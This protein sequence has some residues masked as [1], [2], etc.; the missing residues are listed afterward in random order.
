MG[1][2]GRE[3]RRSR[4]VEVSTD[5]WKTWAEA[6]LTGESVHPAWRLWEWNWQ[7]P[8]VAGPGA[9]M[10]RATDKRNRVQPMT[11]DVGRRN[12]MISH[13]LPVEFEVQ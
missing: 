2:R 13:V 12:V 5:G 8:M 10:A 9:M 11:R 3:S 7:T 4:K 6:T 1:Q